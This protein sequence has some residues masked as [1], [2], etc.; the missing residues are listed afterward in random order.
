MDGLPLTGCL[1]RLGLSFQHARLQLQRPTASEDV[2]AA[3][4]VD[5]GTARQAL[6]SVGLDPDEIGDRSIDA[7]SGGQQRRVALAGL[8]AARPRVL[9]LD[10]PFAGLDDD[11]IRA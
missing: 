5:D 6:L 1:D 10:E 8:I 7:L 11:A 2:R 9:I 4:G 3:A